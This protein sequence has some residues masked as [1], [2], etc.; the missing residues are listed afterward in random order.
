MQKYS[1]KIKVGNFQC[2]CGFSNTYTGG[3]TIYSQV[4]L[5]SGSLNIVRT[6][7]INM[8][9]WKGCLN[10]YLSILILKSFKTILKRYLFQSRCDTANL[11][12]MMDQPRPL[13][14]KSFPFKQHFVLWHIGHHHGP[15]WLVFV[16][17]RRLVLS[18]TYHSASQFHNQH[19][20]TSKIVK[21]QNTIL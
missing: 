20:S 8:L 2:G 5:V 13:L 14:F 1:A 19:G 7:V 9:G 17:F 11:V 16:P 12:V 4:C 3:T 21:P 6:S 18:K 15:V 10:G